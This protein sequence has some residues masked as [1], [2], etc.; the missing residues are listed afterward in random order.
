M[1]L[2]CSCG[3]DGDYA[4][5]YEAPNDYSDMPARKRRAKCS[6]CKELIPHVATVARFRCS[7]GANGR[8]EESIYGDEVPLASRYLC[9]RCADLYFSFVELGFDCVGPDENMIELAKEY[10]AT[11]QPQ[12]TVNGV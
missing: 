12:K 9:E 6:S 1:A 3:Y 4:W 10:A 5:Y 11:Y 8:I 7:R 2:S